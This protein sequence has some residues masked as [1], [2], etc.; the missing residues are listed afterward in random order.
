MDGISLLGL[1]GLSWPWKGWWASIRQNPVGTECG[2]PYS[3][4][5]LLRSLLCWMITWNGNIAFL[6]MITLVKRVRELHAFLVSGIAGHSWRSVLLLLEQ[7]LIVFLDSTRLTLPLTV[8]W[9][10]QWFLSTFQGSSKASPAPCDIVG[11]CYPVEFHCPWQLCKVN[12]TR[13]T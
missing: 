13:L 2:T 4:S 10:Q 5:C 6:I 11:I 9:L 8:M 1:R 7:L 12:R 3:P